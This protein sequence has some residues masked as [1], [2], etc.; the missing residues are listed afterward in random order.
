MAINKLHRYKQIKASDVSSNSS[1][2]TSIASM[3]MDVTN[4]AFYSLITD[5]YTKY[6]H[7][8]RENIKKVHSQAIDKM[9]LRQRSLVATYQIEN[10]PVSN[11][12]YTQLPPVFHLFGMLL[13]YI[14]RILQIDMYGMFEQLANISDVKPLSET[15]TKL[16]KMS[17]MNDVKIL[18]L[19]D[20]PLTY[21]QQINVL[22]F[23]NI[24]YHVVTNSLFQINKEYIPK[25]IEQNLLN[26]FNSIIDTKFKMS[27]VYDKLNDNDPYHVR[28][29][30]KT[31][32]AFG[33]R[34]VKM[35]LKAVPASYKGLF[36]AKTTFPNP[37]DSTSSDYS[38]QDD[39]DEFIDSITIPHDKINSP[40]FL[41]NV[42]TESY[43]SIGK[44][45]D[46][47][48][49]M[50]TQDNKIYWSKFK[51]AYGILPVYIGRRDVY[52]KKEYE[53]LLVA[54][55]ECCETKYHTKRILDQNLFCPNTAGVD[56]NFQGTKYA[57]LAV[58]GTFVESS[59]ITGSIDDVEFLYINPF[60]FDEGAPTNGS[61]CESIREILLKFDS[62][63]FCAYK[64][65]TKADFP[66]TDG[67]P[68]TETFDTISSV[69]N[70]NSGDSLCCDSA[71]F[72]DF[73]DILKQVS[74]GLLF[75][76]NK[77]CNSPILVDTRN[78]S[79]NKVSL[80]GKDYPVL[81]LDRIKCLIQSSATAIIYVTD[82]NC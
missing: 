82:I 18:D 79:S 31:M 47:H 55:V 39:I 66:C 36:G 44:F 35:Q 24:F 51:R 1:V 72:K 15:E 64:K 65:P 69:I 76:S 12:V 52:K 40:D 10:L 45:L 5:L 13:P 61:V 32:L 26:H 19:N 37:V 17:I 62:H 67:K 6:A 2:I 78:G 8:I 48:T 71:I 42:G 68:P 57:P 20:M 49:K 77:T 28:V 4:N 34:P 29:L 14:S 38:S 50:V 16:I 27:C 22:V 23:M 75:L 43:L 58:M 7:V 9:I 80:G 25:M 81:Q 30:R 59:E 54:N 73:K 53:Q 33:I 41:E 56:N 3:P 21:E 70:S 63:F 60:S 46:N 74:I 11:N